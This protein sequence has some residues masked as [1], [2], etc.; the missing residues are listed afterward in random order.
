MQP[1]MPGSQ[2]RPW[3]RWQFPCTS[4][5]QPQPLIGHPSSVAGPDRLSAE[6]GMIDDHGATGNG[7]IADHYPAA[8]RKDIGLC[9]AISP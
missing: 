4:C 2:G 1:F 7:A 8:P 3:T 5:G 9:R 6:A